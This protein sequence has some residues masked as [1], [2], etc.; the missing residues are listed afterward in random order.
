MKIVLVGDRS[1]SALYAFMGALEAFGL[2]PHRYMVN[3]TNGG[4][5]TMNQVTP[6]EMVSMVES[7]DGLVLK[8]T[9]GNKWRATMPSEIEKSDFV[10]ITPDQIYELADL[11]PDESIIIVLI[12]ES[13]V[14]HTEEKDMS[15][16][17]RKL[18]DIFGRFTE[19]V[20]G[21]AHA[22]A[23]YKVNPWETDCTRFA[24]YVANKKKSHDNLQ[25]IVWQLIESGN[26]EFTGDID[27]QGRPLRHD[28]TYKVLQY[29]MDKE[30]PTY[31]PV[32]LFTSNVMYD[33]E[34]FV[35][36]MRIWLESGVDVTG[37][38]REVT[39]RIRRQEE[40]NDEVD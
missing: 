19:E 34:G 30:L 27:V 21:R 15:D 33:N 18:Q 16:T 26:I 39:D 31:V 40:T 35:H 38:C 17:D 32:D 2:N 37:C 28:R 24:E 7:E 4:Q 13:D 1:N 23:V 36:T 11:L 20:S 12:T 10:T 29:E 22:A 9:D 8:S 6:D 14:A 3:T 25:A 5:L